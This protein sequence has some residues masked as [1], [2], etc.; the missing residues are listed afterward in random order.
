MKVSPYFEKHKE[1][2][3]YAQHK[4]TRLFGDLR[5]GRPPPPPPPLKLTNTGGAGYI[6]I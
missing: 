2:R 6:A 1:E 4:D 3:G 5:G